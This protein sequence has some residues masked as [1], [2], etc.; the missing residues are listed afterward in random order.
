[1]KFFQLVFG[2]YPLKVKG[3]AQAPRHNVLT[4]RPLSTLGG[5]HHMMSTKINSG[6]SLSV[7][8]ALLHTPPGVWLAQEITFGEVPQTTK[9]ISATIVW[10]LQAS[11]SMFLLP[12]TWGQCLVWGERAALEA[13]PLFEGPG[14]KI[15]HKCLP[16]SLKR[17]L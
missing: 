13:V 12:C 17:F 1:L 11:S 7:T 2:H 9:E 14:G 3:R 8:H 5:A 6:C 15:S 4:A 16:T 10:N